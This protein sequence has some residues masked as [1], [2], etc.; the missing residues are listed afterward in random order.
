MGNDA[1]PA[2]IGWHASL[3]IRQSLDTLRGLPEPCGRAIWQDV[4]SFIE[5]TSTT[6]LAEVAEVGGISVQAYPDLPGNSEDSRYLTAEQR[7]PAR[8]P[9]SSF[10]SA[11]RLPQSRS[12]QHRASSVE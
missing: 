4:E 11:A 5:V 6:N 9:V 2:P 3:L 10:V 8:S 12:R 7:S 1:R